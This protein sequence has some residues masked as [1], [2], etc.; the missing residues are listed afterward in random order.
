MPTRH[1]SS[2]MRDYYVHWIFHEKLANYRPCSRISRNK[3]VISRITGVIYKKVYYIKCEISLPCSKQKY[4]TRGIYPKYSKKSCYVLYLHEKSQ[5]AVPLYSGV[6][7]EL[8]TY[9]D[10]TCSVEEFEYSKP[11]GLIAPKE[12]G[13][14]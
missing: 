10:F 3:S 9:F 6:V 12:I 5:E 14:T 8:L 2:G 1:S 4:I 13:Y 7:E 11:S